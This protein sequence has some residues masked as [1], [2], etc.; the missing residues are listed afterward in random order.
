MATSFDMPATLKR[1]LFIFLILVLLAAAALFAHWFLIGRHHEHTDNAYVQGEI[2]RVSS[3]LAARIERVH[4][5]EN[6]HV[7]CGALLVT[8]EVAD[9]RLAFEHACGNL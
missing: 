1:R 4:V 6:Q 9:F 2:T 5:E 8:L 7:E 3:Q